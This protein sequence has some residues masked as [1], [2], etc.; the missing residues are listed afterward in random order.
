MIKKIV[1]GLAVLVAV[2]AA[3]AYVLPRQ[4]HVERS[5]TIDAPP[6]TVF[7]LVNSFQRSAEWS[8]WHERDPNMAVSLDGPVAGVGAKM[9]WSSNNPQ[10]GRGSQEIITSEPSTYVRSRLSFDGQQGAESFFNLTRVDDGT[11]VVWGFET[12]LGMNPLC[13]YM[14][15]LMDRWVGGD[16]ERGLEKLKGIAETGS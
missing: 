9:S 14:G 8:P 1:I 16:F 3:G 11:E 5:I 7:D 4:I 2:L 13:R 12:D 10:V 6:E 15:L